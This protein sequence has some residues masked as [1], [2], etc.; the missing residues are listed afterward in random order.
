MNVGKEAPVGACHGGVP[1]LFAKVARPVGA[2]EVHRTDEA[3]IV[4]LL[5]T[6]LQSCTSLKMTADAHA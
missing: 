3:C 5:A 2:I 4:S 1:R 6:H